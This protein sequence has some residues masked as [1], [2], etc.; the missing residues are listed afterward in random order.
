MED[1]IIIGAGAALSL[2]HIFFQLVME[3]SIGILVTTGRVEDG[4]SSRIASHSLVQGL[5]NKRIVVSLAYYERH[6][7]AVI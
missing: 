6:N 7:Q 5:E 1:C 2:I 4:M 3:C